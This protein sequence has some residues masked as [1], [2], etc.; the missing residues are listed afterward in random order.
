MNYS[1]HYRHDYNQNRFLFLN[2]NFQS[3]IAVVEQLYEDIKNDN[4]EG[5][6]KFQWKF[7]RKQQKDYLKLIE[8]KDKVTL[9]KT[10]KNKLLK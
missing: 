6:L 10:I 2:L 1:L 4:F 9:R 3:N 8:A 5:R 7:K